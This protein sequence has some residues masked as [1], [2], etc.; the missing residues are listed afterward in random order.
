MGFHH[1]PAPLGDYKQSRVHLFLWE[2]CTWSQIMNNFF[3]PHRHQDT[4]WTHFSQTHIFWTFWHKNG[5]FQT[6]KSGENYICSRPVSVSATHSHEICEP[7]LPALFHNGHKRTFKWFYRW[8]HEL[9]VQT[10]IKQISCDA[11]SICFNPF[12]R[13]YNTSRRGGGMVASNCLH[14]RVTPPSLETGSVYT[15]S[16]LWHSVQ[17]RILF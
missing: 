12:T 14:G 1:G 7:V 15:I 17:W 5:I 16:H 11:K 10:Y 4:Y 9:K 2:K 8:N 6:D 13:H 3:S